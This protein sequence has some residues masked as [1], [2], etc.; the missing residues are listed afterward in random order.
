M[1]NIFN[2]LDSETTNG[3][4]YACTGMSSAY[5]K[6]FRERPSRTMKIL[7]RFHIRK[8]FSNALER[9]QAD[10]MRQL[11]RYGY[12]PILTTSRW[13]FFENGRKSN[14]THTF[15]LRE[16]LLYHLEPIRAFLISEDFNRF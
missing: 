16:L 13:R 12:E 7:D 6:I 3:T 1:S 14:C 11:R 10:L 15:R 2:L 4:K 9:V 5:L 8:K